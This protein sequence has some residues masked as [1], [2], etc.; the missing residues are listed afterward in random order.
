MNNHFDVVGISSG[1]KYLNDINSQEGVRTIEVNMSRKISP[2]MDLVSLFNMIITLLKEKPEIVHTHTPKAG[3]IGMLASWICRVPIRLHTVAGLPVME[4]TGLKRKVLLIVEK[5][6]Y[7]CATKVYPNSLGL[8]DFILER[9]L[10]YPSKLKVIGH[11][12]SNGIDMKFFDPSI[13]HFEDIK[14]RYNLENK[15]V[16]LF[17][18]RVV[19]DK[20]VNELIYAFNKI[21]KMHENVSLLLVGPFENNLNPISAESFKIIHSNKNI[22]SI[23]F[24][25]D[26]RP[27]FA[28]CDVFVL[29]TYREGFPNVLLQACSMSIPCIATDINGCNE[30]ITNNFNGLIIKPKDRLDLYNAMKKYLLDERLLKKLSMHSRKDIYKKYQRENFHHFLLEE[31]KELLKSKNYN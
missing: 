22:Q 7:F 10:T 24:I 4:A 14:K 3:I 12:S 18:G 13:K 30:I 5:I 20:G 16:F 9:Q 31:Y 6:T 28:C 17:V 21:S 11:G 26:V 29:P 15:F 23:G 1:G 19:S 8:M 25:D 27:Y 2:I